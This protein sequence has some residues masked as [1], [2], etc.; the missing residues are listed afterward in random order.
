V[1]AAI[2]VVV[3]GVVVLLLRVPGIPAWETAYAEDGAVFL[4]SALARPWHLLSP[5][6][7]YEE[8]G[9]RLIAQL[10]AT[11]VPIVDAAAGFAIAGALISS[12]SALFMY[13]ASEGYIRSRWLRAALGAALLLLPI[14]PLEIIDSGVNTPW[15][16]LTATFFAILWR[17]RGWPGMTAAALIAFYAC[18][19]EIVAGILAPLVLL[20]L[21]ALPRWRE[22]AV[23]AGWLA[24]M[25]LQALILVQ[26]Y[27]QHAQRIGPLATPL[28]A[29]SFYV[30]GVVLRAAGWR[31]SLYLTEIAGAGGATIIVGAVLAVLIGCAVVTG[32]RRVRVFA[33]VALVTGFAEALFTATVTNWAGTAPPSAGYLPAA[34]YATLPIVLLDAIGVVAADGLL[35]RSGG[36]HAADAALPGRRGPRGRIRP[37][38][39]IAIVALACVL[40]SGWVADYRYPGWRGSSANYWPPYARPWARACA[41]H[42]DGEIH[43]PQLGT[44]LWDP[45]SWVAVRCSRVRL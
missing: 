34:R 17:P 39:G 7:G 43:M 2:A 36:R 37:R 35:L 25:L 32:D 42:P 28:Q 8:L 31:L 33:T 1:A 10:V 12:A 18:S 11:T 41:R 14:A 15:Y 26:S 38:A 6:N 5:Y 30:N 3:A 29:A 45:P 19:S 23:T 13:H 20:R 40:G 22:H 27:A 16:A 21:I 24:G 4:P 44:T 9:P